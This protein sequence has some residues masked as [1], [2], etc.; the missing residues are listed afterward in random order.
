MCRREKRGV[1][2]GEVLGD[3]SRDDMGETGVGGEWEGVDES[4]GLTSVTA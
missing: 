4:E 1:M 2:P 3:D